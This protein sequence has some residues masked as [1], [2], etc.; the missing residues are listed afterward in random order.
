MASSRPD[1]DGT[2]SSA[3]AA[4]SPPVESPDPALPGRPGAIAARAKAG[5]GAEAAAAEAV[6]EA[7][8]AWSADGKVTAAKGA[9]AK[10]KA[11]N[12]RAVAEAAAAAS[13]AAEVEA[14]AV[15]EA[16]A[17]AAIEAQ[18]ARD[19]GR[20]WIRIDRRLDRLVAGL[21]A[22]GVLGDVFAAQHYVVEAVLLHRAVRAGKGTLENLDPGSAQPTVWV[23]AG[24][25]AVFAVA[26]AAAVLLIARGKPIGFAAVQAGGAVLLP[27]RLLAFLAGYLR[28]QDYVGSVPGGSRDPSYHSA[29]VGQSFGAAVGV[30]ALVVVLA[31]LLGGGLWRWF[32]P[33]LTTGEPPTGPS[34][35]SIKVARVMALAATLIAMVVPVA[36]VRPV[37]AGLKL[38]SE[39]PII[40]AVT[41][42]LAVTALLAA[43]ATIAVR[44]DRPLVR[45]LALGIVV[46]IASLT[47]IV[48]V[49]EWFYADVAFGSDAVHGV[50]GPWTA[51]VISG[52]VSCCLLTAAAI[53]LV[54][55]TRTAVTAR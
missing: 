29:I 43:A 24:L 36:W 7:P 45:R 39:W 31:V 10:T 20:G 3:K 55:P 9:K 38:P 17:L 37:G 13:T 33:D 40:A 30:A 25:A 44:P 18:P 11:A 48:M 16:E 2:S 27:A 6:G 1:A 35:R 54:R 8:L 46:V 5:A 4:D 26:G 15:A 34:G 22:I 32:R 19:R 42:V 53:A 47:W 14:E 50:A 49:W 28:Y 51:A 23:L 41:G 12:A 52:F 21:L